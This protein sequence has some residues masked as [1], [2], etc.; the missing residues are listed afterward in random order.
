MPAQNWESYTVMNSHQSILS[1]ALCRISRPQATATATSQGPKGS[2]QQAT[3]TSTTTAPRKPT[4]LQLTMNTCARCV[5]YTRCHI[6]TRNTA[7]QHFGD[8]Q[9]QHDTRKHTARNDV[10]PYKRTQN[11]PQ[12][13]QSKHTTRPWHWKET[14][15]IAGWS[16]ET[17]R[18]TFGT[19]AHKQRE[20]RRAHPT[21]Q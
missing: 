11:T 13:T 7:T 4:N 17:K 3:T 12:R 1:S 2:R 10:T 19:H 21:R 8:P 6:N 5:G 20:G 18:A 9:I 15:P 14:Q 16:R